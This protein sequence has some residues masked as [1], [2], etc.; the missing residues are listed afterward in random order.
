MGLDLKEDIHQTIL[1]CFREDI[2]HLC[3]FLCGSQSFIQP[4][5]IKFLSNVIIFI[6]LKLLHEIS[7]CK[8]RLSFEGHRFIRKLFFAL[9]AEA[10]FNIGTEGFI[11]DGS[12]PLKSLKYLIEFR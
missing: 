10:T 9:I 6:G 5:R 4:I 7:E 2:M 11:G 8:D 3:Q 12:L 1:K